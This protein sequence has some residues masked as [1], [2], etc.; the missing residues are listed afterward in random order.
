[1]L[2]FMLQYPF[3]ICV[4]WLVLSIFIADISIKSR[5]SWISVMVK[6]FTRTPCGL[7]VQTFTH[8]FVVQIPKIKKEKE[9]L[10]MYSSL[11]LYVYVYLFFPFIFLSVQASL[12]LRLILRDNPP[13]LTTFGCYGNK[14]LIKNK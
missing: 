14:Y 3:T 10:E 1:M 13:D 6:T 8:S 12:P 5:Y 4:L 11:Y 9:I 2:L 7:V